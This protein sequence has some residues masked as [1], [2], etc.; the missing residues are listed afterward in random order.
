VGYKA[1]LLEKPYFNVLQLRLGFSHD[2]FIKFP[3]S[4][5]IQCFKTNAKIY[6]LGNLY[7]KVLEITSTIRSYKK[8]EPYKGK[9]ILYLT[10][11][12]ILKEGKKL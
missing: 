12:I 5:C 9:G 1:F 6:I 11:D 4:I 10:E 7:Q 3:T 8:P 2:I